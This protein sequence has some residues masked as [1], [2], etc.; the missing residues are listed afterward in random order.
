MFLLHQGVLIWCKRK[1]FG[2][3]WRP[4]VQRWLKYGERRVVFF[5]SIWIWSNSSILNCCFVIIFCVHLFV[6]RIW[7]LPFHES[8]PIAIE[9]CNALLN[10][11]AS[12]LNTFKYIWIYTCVWSYYILSFQ[13]C[14]SYSYDLLLNFNFHL[15]RITKSK[16]RKLGLFQLITL[17]WNSGFKNYKE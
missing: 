16:N 9:I 14:L 17:W 13:N 12:F 7:Q 1:N 2:I 8:Q 10:S 11:F 3:S 4:D 5:V 15:V 6:Q